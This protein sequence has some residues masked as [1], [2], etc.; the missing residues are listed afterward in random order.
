MCL[1]DP[2]VRGIRCNHVGL[3]LLGL[4]I[5]NLVKANYCYEFCL[6]STLADLYVK[7]L[8]TWRVGAV[9]QVASIPDMKSDGVTSMLV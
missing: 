2:S 8:R 3:F 7:K 9:I 1:L 5:E 6:S 4:P